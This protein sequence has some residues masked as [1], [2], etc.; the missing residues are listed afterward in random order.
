MDSPVLPPGYWA[1][2]HHRLRQ[3]GIK[4]CA[5]MPRTLLGF[6]RSG[7]KYQARSILQGSVARGRSRQ[8]KTQPL[9]L[10][11]ASADAVRA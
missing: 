6:H 11:F 2:N 3:E 10:G 5:K 8:K 1:S 4:G 7:F 9:G